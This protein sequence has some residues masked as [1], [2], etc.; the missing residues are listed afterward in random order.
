MFVVVPPHFAAAKLVQFLKGRS[1]RMLQHESP[2]P[3][4]T[5][6]GSAFLGAGLLLRDGRRSRRTGGGYG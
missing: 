2:L 4:E 3:P 1:S 6:L 5:L